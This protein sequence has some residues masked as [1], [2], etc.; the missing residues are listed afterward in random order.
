MKYM[1]RMTALMGVLVGMT[2]C[3]DLLFT[4]PLALKEDTTFD[5]GLVG[6]WYDQEDTVITVTA[7]DSPVLEI[8]VIGTKDGETFRLAGRLVKIGAHTLLDVTDK[9]VGLY[10]VP[11]HMWIHLEKKGKG[12]R[13]QYLHSKWLRERVWEA[14]LAAFISPVETTVVTA[15]GEQLREFARKYAVMAEGRGEPMD[16]VPFRKE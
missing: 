4:E 15:P 7:P 9:K 8:L 5:A 2:G 10:G 6:T 11:G 14:R 1:L 13:I 16:L 12:W 3:G